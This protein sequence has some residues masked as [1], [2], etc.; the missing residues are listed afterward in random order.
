MK[1]D[2]R[3][4]LAGSA[5]LMMVPKKLQREEGYLIA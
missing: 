3:W 1:R 2:Q 5:T 4:L